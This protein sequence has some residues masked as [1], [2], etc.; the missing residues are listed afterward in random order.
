VRLGYC[1]DGPIRNCAFSNIVM[2][3]TRTGINMIVPRIREPADGFVFEHGPAISGIAFNNLVMDTRIALYLWV[4]EEASQPAGIRDV[5]ISNVIAT[6]ERACY[7]GGSPSMPIERVRLSDV[8]LTVRGEMDDAMAE[9]PYPYPVFDDWVRRGIPHGIYARHARDL[10]FHGIRVNWGHVSGA[11]R[12]AMRFE[13]TQDLH[14][15]SVIADAAPGA[16]RAAVEMS[17]A[18]GVT[19]RGCRRTSNGEA[20]F[21]GLGPR[22]KGVSD[23]TR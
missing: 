14:L 3:H 21:L 16:A 18:R 9:V 17:D 19:L 13:H 7:I 4:G 10:E 6:T 22:V 1:G 2:S 5:Q 11:W 12:S 8:S 23:D 20:P 15:D